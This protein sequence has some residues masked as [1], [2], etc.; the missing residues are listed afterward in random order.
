MRRKT[1]RKRRTGKK[2]EDYNRKRMKRRR[3]RADLGDKEERERRKMKKKGKEKN[4]KTKQIAMHNRRL[5]KTFSQVPQ[6]TFITSCYC[7][8]VI[9]QKC[10]SLGAN[11]Q[12]CFIV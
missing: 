2:D 1:I 4:N 6:Q 8:F 9:N 11:C 3:E 5:M 7:Q 12:D 10:S